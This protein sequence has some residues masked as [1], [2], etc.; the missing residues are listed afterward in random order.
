[1]S[2][3]NAMA[4]VIKYNGKSNNRVR[5]ISIILFVVRYDTSFTQVKDEALAF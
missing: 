3:F 5:I 2:P 4:W 1:M